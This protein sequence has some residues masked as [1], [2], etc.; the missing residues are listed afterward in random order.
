MVGTT[1]VYIDMIFFAFYGYVEYIFFQP[2][3]T[4]LLDV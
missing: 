2:I 4:T 1:Y 3:F